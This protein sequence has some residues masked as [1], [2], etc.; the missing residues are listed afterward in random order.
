MFKVGK[1]VNW[2]GRVE[3]MRWLER[4]FEGGERQE[5]WRVVRILEGCMVWRG[6]VLWLQGN[7]VE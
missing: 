7:V 2:A 1:G 6:R 4:G 3:A 5:V